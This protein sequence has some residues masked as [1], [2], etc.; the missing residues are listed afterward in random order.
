MEY[1]YQIY[2]Y[3]FNLCMCT[4]AYICI[5]IYSTFP[6]CH[7][8]VRVL[9]AF[10]QSLSCV[11]VISWTAS[12]EASLSFTVSWSL[13]KLMSLSRWCYP[14]ISPLMPLFSSCP[15]SFPESRSFPMS[16]LFPSGG[17]RIGASVLASVL[18]MNIQDWFP[19]GWTSWISLQSKGLS[20]VFSNITGQKHQFFSTQPSFWSNSHIHTGLLEKP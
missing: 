6:W 12:C 18:P 7:S 11:F 2:M 16:Q 10:I 13:I 8:L 9:G 17:Q 1:I 14:T 3:I 4:Y 15:Q 5:Y 20:R 19:L